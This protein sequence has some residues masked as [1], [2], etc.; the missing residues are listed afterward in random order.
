MPA[1][2]FTP[3]ILFLLIV[4]SLGIAQTT[5]PAR[6][7]PVVVELFTSEGCSSCPPADDLLRALSGQRTDA[8]QPILV[9]S[10]HVTYWNRLGWTDPFSS[11]TFTERQEAYG[12]RF[13]LDSVYTPQMVV[14]GSIQV[15]G[16]DRAAVKRAIRQTDGTS[17]V[18]VESLSAELKNSSLK[19]RVNF[20]G[21]P[22]ADTDIVAVIAD[23]TDASH[24]VRGENSGS[25]LA[26]VSVARTL[27]RFR[28]DR[29]EFEL[30][31]PPPGR[32][33]TSQP[34]H[35][36]VFLQ[37]TGSDEI[38]AARTVPISTTADVRAHR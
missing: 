14:N 24:V 38:L 10:E 13:R 5:K 35:L 25:T 1:T 30:P 21:I 9:L 2:R 8:G 15:L 28:S 11:D 31:F 29:R 37:K 4:S 26:H 20:A 23:D 34:R 12:Q 27:S 3:K 6:G 33:V 32:N 17:A 36:L 19:V 18:M 16:S 7:R 22:P